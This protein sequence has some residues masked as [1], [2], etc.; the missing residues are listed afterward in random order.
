MLVFQDGKVN[1]KKMKVEKI[2]K[3]S[4]RSASLDRKIIVA[5]PF[6][7]PEINFLL[8]L[9]FCSIVASRST[10]RSFFKNDRELKSLAQ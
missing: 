9:F 2:I 4:A 10:N 8:K 1:F 3:F 6:D 7:L 5:H